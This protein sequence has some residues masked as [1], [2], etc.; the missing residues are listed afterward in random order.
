[1][2][3]VADIEK[4][5]N[6]FKNSLTLYREQTEKWYAQ[7]ADAVSEKTDMPSLLGMERVI[8]VGGTSK[9][10]SMTDGSFTSNVARCPLKGPLLIESKFESVYDI[11]LGGIQVEVIPVKGG[12]ATKLMLDSKGKASFQGKP[13]ELYKIRVQ[14]EV[15][16]AQVNALFKSYDG[17]TGELE[18]WLRKEWAVFKPQWSTQSAAA[19][20][21]AV[22]NGILAG[23][24]E[25]IKGVWDGITLIL[26]ILQNPMKYADRLGAGA[27]KLAKL[28]KEAPDVMRKA[29]LFASDEAALFLL[30]RSAS[31]WLSALPP[32]QIAGEAAK[33]VSSAVVS[34]LIDIVLG[35]VLTIALEGMGV[36]YLALRL[37]K[38]GQVIVKAATRFVEAVFKIINSFMGYIKKYTEVAAR[39]IQTAAKKGVVQVRFDGRKN[40]VLGGKKAAPDASRSATTPARRNADSASNT[41]TS[42]CPVSMVTGEE[43]LTLTDGQLDGL[44]PFE[45]TRLYRTSAAELNCGLGYGWSHALAQRVEIDGE[46]VVW[47]DH[48]NRSTTFP[49]PSEQRPAITNTLSRA[50]IFLGDDPSELILCQAGKSPRF[51]HFRYNS[52]GASLIAISDNYDNRLHITRDIQGRI[53]RVDNGAGRALLLRYDRTL[54]VAVDYQQFTPADNLEDAWSTV[55]TLVSYSYDAQ[56][57]LIEA[58]NAAGE[59]ERYAYDKQNVILER[60]MAGGASFFWE[61]ENQG[62]DSRC[63]HHWANFAQMDQRYVWDDK[64]SVTAINADGSEE[65]YTHDEQARLISKV[66]PDGAEHLK[67]YDEKGRLIAEKDPL[68]A[69]TEYHYDEAG[70]MVAVI[71]P[72][73]EPTGYEY[74]NGRV[75]E[76]RRGNTTWKYQRNYQGDITQQTDPHGN[77]THYRYD[78]QGRLLEITH[79]DGSRH[80]LGWNGLGQL[81]E[82]RLPDGGQR[83]YRYDALGRQITRQDES[84]AITHYQWDAANRLAQ[85][86]L[87]GGATRAFSY[88]A[89]GKVTAERDELGRITRYE[90]ADNLHLVSR[91]I[92]PDGSQLRYRYDNARLLLTDIE[93]ERGEQYHLDYYSNGLIQQETGFDGRRTAYAYDLNG[94]LLKKTEFGDDGSELV[95]EY[96]RDAAGRLLVK[97][98][99][100]GEEIHYS[101]DALGR[102]VNVDD[103]HWPLAYEYDLQDRLITE[104]Q[105]WG[106]LRYEYDKLGQLS[107]C[108][109]PDGSKLDYR[110]A[111]GG[112]L[113]SIDLNGSRL[114]SHQ[115]NAG[116]EQQRQ[117]GLLLSQYQY[118]EQGRLQTHSVSQQQHGQQHNLYRRAYAYDANGNLAGIDDSRKGNLRYHYDPLDRL[119]NVRGATPESF[120]HD[121]AGNLLGQGDQPAANLANVKGNRLLMQG[122]RHYDYDAFGNLSRERRGAGQKLVTEYQYDC[123]HRLIGVSLPG[124]STATYKY[125]AFGRRIGKT[126]DGRTTEFLWQGERLIAESAE[127]RYR[128]YIYEPGTFR[129]LAMLDGEGPAQATPFYYQLDHLGTPQELTAY[130]GEIMWSAKYRAYGN[131]AALDVSEID[132]PLRFQGQ[133]FDT[134]TGLHYNRHRYYNPSSGR[135]LT[136]D[137]IKLAGGV[138]NYQYVPNP[139][140]WVDPLG[141][142]SKQCDGPETPDNAAHNAAKYAGLK[143]DLKTTEAANDLVESLR[144]TGRL[145]SNY[146][147]KAQAKQNG[148]EPGKALNNNVPGGQLGGD[149]FYNDTN[150]LPSAPGRTWYEAD[151][152]INNTI[153]RAKQPGTRLLYSND[154]LLYI[155]SD[156]YDTVSSIGKWK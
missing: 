91:R 17:L 14:N 54:I 108:R 137:P 138:N 141:L 125:D 98:L 7:A 90:Y 140:G 104:H 69:V 45:W 86:T 24:W 49:L 126:V 27:E 83:K 74:D 3:R 146:V 21:K 100:D 62:K 103:G 101:Y 20:L 107:H 10:V 9:A 139:T 145:P 25:A 19:S 124:G 39:G 41:C 131:L 127:N 118:D 143:R 61:W 72:E 150:V 26:D 34:I 122:D 55:Q 119:I 132:N 148:W 80:Q 42:G 56:H 89:Y 81:L 106:T 30:V 79:A 71:P 113:S 84:G 130:S 142:A 4:Q 23:S 15:T 48:E 120:A 154:G 57:R 76:V 16:P 97:T 85:I 94:K 68:G 77:Q 5:L 28:A 75:S 12:A 2:G 135:F 47:T 64:G 96:Q 60:Q 78:R 73:D 93:N 67:A 36:V 18:G 40:S 116:R 66:D 22:G 35:I 92:N 11:P 65:I 52:K 31:I 133:Y 50:A 99:A 102:L 115:F 151:V 82:E 33:A 95:T 149:V 43:L 123:Q 51:Y 53:K 1:M 46:S 112:Q 147:T 121:P 59:A 136:P 153:S 109:L 114:T 63:I 105:G 128:S 44:L 32:T 70:D 144:T 8:K 6:S 13:G 129:P 111:P 152:G 88:N 38:Y 110:H 87:P 134:E 58:K 156:H 29:M 155:T 117:Q 37:K